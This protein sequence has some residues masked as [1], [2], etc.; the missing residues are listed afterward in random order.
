MFDMGG[1]GILVCVTQVSF[2]IY[3]RLEVDVKC[4]VFLLFFFYYFAAAMIICRMM[5]SVKSVFF[6]I[7]LPELNI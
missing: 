3:S 7:S 5:T 1:E 4:L 2:F 6:V